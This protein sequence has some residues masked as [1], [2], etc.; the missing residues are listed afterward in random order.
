MLISRPCLPIKDDVSQDLKPNLFK[1]ISLWKKV[2][3]LKGL[4]WGFA[5]FSQCWGTPLGSQCLAG[6]LVLM[7]R[8][9]HISLVSVC[10]MLGSPILYPV[11]GL[12]VAQVAESVDSVVSPVVNEVGGMSW[13]LSPFSAQLIKQSTASFHKV[14]DSTFN[15]SLEQ[16][17]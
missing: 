15:T 13:A 11:Q 5:L 9:L 7:L 4:C 6:P 16:G 8:R 2:V 1:Y 17:T 12:G 10:F 14:A 3:V